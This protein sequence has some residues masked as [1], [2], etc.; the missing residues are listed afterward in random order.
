MKVPI[1]AV[2]LSQ[3]SVK[4]RLMLLSK[5]SVKLKLSSAIGLPIVLMFVVTGV[6][7]LNINAIKETN[8]WVSHT[9]N[10]LGNTDKILASAVNMETGMRGY[11]L[12]GKP[13]FL[14]PYQIGEQS[15]YQYI[16]DLKKTVS[17]NPPQVERLE[18]IRQELKKWQANVTEPAIALRTNIGDAKTMNDMADL[19]G[20][21]QG[22]VYF[23]RFREL[24]NTFIEREK[25]LLTSRFKD[26]EDAKA[27]IRR[28]F[29]AIDEQLE[30]MTDAQRWVT[31]TYEV[32]DKANGVLLAAINM[33]TGMRGYLLAG[34]D[35]FLAP[36]QEGQA[37]FKNEITRLR[38]TVS[39]NPAQVQ[40]LDEINNTIN[41]WV[42]NVTEPTIKLRREIG[43]AK[44]M[45]DMAD[46]VGEARGKEYFN[47]FRAIISEFSGIEQSLMQERERANESTMSNTKIIIIISVCLAALIGI[48]LA[49]MVVR[50]LLSQLGGEPRDVNRITARIAEGDLTVNF[51]SDLP[52]GSI[53]ASLRDMSQNLK[54][55]FAEIQSTSSE[56]A[57]A[58]EQTSVIAQQTSHSTS[59]QLDE[60]TLVATAMTQMSASVN[61]VANNVSN[62]ADASY[63]ANQLTIKGRE[64][65]NQTVHQIREVNEDIKNAATVIRELDQGTQNVSSIVDSIKSIAEQ[66]NLLALNAAIE[67][68][69]AGSQG[70]G[71]AVVADEVR[72]LAGRTQIATTEISKTIQQLQTGAVKAV[73]VMEQSQDQAQKAS[74]KTALTDDTLNTIQA[75]I[76]QI[77]DMNTQIA[78]ASVEQNSVVEEINRNVV[79][80]NEIAEHTSSGAHQ[81]AETG[82]ELTRLA[83]NLERLMGR[84]TLS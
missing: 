84:F 62:A 71:F 51:D 30:I 2:Y 42:K 6:I 74:E 15:I 53:F 5:A 11:L 56:L 36:Y 4:V 76:G 12:A 72:V 9:H 83:S 17:D 75:A 27:Q 50:D 49:I 3:R 47:R 21:A 45:D 79:K 8:D 40:L 38:K 70:R 82:R 14:E 58:A 33:E 59:Q 43:D 80:V 39:D 61:E 34:K 29:G 52:Q 20:K 26:F 23:D 77:S 10:V 41:D 73:S 69:R 65:M 22:K 55:I 24:I 81:V 32:I 54:T 7:Y 18:N 63:E 31:H 67:A 25:I 66:T 19:V 48:G 1:T 13:S 57:A 44:T 16:D 60:T 78:S 46:L 37:G 35:E 28:G 68:A 64:L